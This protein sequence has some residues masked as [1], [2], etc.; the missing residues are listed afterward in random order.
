MTSVHAWSQF[1]WEAFD[2]HSNVGGT[3]SEF[4]TPKDKYGK[5][6]FAPLGTSPVQLHPSLVFIDFVLDNTVAAQNFEYNMSNILD[7]PLYIL[8]QFLVARLTFS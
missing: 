3:C 1:E 5:K 6:L 7:K 4:I 2:N 8:V